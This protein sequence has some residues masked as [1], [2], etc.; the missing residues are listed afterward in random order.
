MLPSIMMATAPMGEQRL[1]QEV[2]NWVCGERFWGRQAELGHL[3]SLLR[4]GASVSLTAPRRIGKTSLMR[5][6]GRR[7]AGDFAVLHVDLQRAKRAADLVVELSLESRLQRDLWSRTRE[8]FRNAIGGVE[9]LSYDELSVK[10]SGGLTGGWQRRGDRLLEEFANERPTIIFI[11][12]LPI[13]VNRLLK[14]PDYQLTAARVAEVDELLSWLRAMVIRHRGRLRFVVAGSIGLGPVLRQ[15]KLS[16]A[17]NVFTPFELEPWDEATALG[18]LRALANNYGVR[19]EAAAPERVV[20]LLGCLVPHYVQ[21]FWAQLR[22]DANKRHVFYLTVADVER[23]FE[24]R[25]M[26]AH[27]QAELSHFEER[28]GLVLGKQLLPLTLDLLS[29]AA[30]ADGLAHDA[31]VAL[32][33]DHGPPRGLDDMREV[34]DVLVH[35]GYLFLDADGRH[36]FVSHLVHEWWRRRYQLS[37]VPLAQRSAVSA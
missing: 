10:F 34:I 30:L 16:A 5:E 35:D 23:V 6:A 28:L 19:W 18:A 2:G 32:C 37:Y 25:M 3:C 33:E 36:R 26:S 9:E 12:E 15:A 4:E 7:L 20:E 31:A 27:G 8:V 13:L 1:V 21:M 29:E 22:L 17:L 24:R 14:G 11:D